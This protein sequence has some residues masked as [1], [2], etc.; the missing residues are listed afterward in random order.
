MQIGDTRFVHLVSDQG[1]VKD[2]EKKVRPRTDNEEV[3]SD[4]YVEASD[5]AGSQIMDP[6]KMMG[7][8]RQKSFNMGDVKD[9]VEELKN[10]R[11]F[12]A[13]EAE[14]KDIKRELKALHGE[15]TADGWKNVKPEDKKRLEWVNLAEAGVKSS[16]D[17]IKH[18]RRNI[19][20]EKISAE[21]GGEIPS[22]Y[23]SY[24]KDTNVPAGE[25]REILKVTD[26]I[27]STD[28]K[29]KLRGNN[30]SMLMRGD[31]WS[32]KMRLLDD[33]IQNPVKNGKPVEV[34]AEYY[35][36]GSPEM[37]GRL[38]KAAES[39]AKVRAVLDPG[40]IAGAGKNT[41]DATSLGVR[42]DVVEQLT[43][44]MEGHD[45]GVTLYPNK[46]Q[47]GGRDEIMHRKIFR[48][49]EEV[50]FGG[51][52][53]SSGSGENV[54]FGMMIEGPAARRIG[55]EFK[56]D[57][58]TSTGKSLEDIYGSQ[59]DTIRSEDSTIKMSGYGFEGLLSSAYGAKAGLTGSETHE[60]K[61]NKLINAAKAEGV[62]VAELGDF[63]DADHDGRVSSMDVRDSL[64]N[65]HQRSVTLSAR[66]KEFLASQ[67]EATVDRV[68]GDKNI[69]ALR[70]INLPEGKTPGGVEGRDVLAVGSSS[71]ERQALVLDAIASA[72]KHIKISAFVLNDEI[73]KLLVEKKREKEAK[74]ENFQVQVIMDPG[75]YGY[76]G[77]PNEP[78]YK[79]LEDA[80]IPVKWSLLDRTDPN[81]DRKNHSKLIM[82]DKM[83]LTGST[84][85]SSK[86]LRN[87]WEVSD[88]VYY[89]E[90]DPDSIRKQQVIEQDF[91]RMWKNEAID[92][93]TKTQAANHYQNYEGDDKAIKIDRYRNTLLRTFCQEISQYETDI[94]TQIHQ[95]GE[96]SDVRSVVAQKVN[97]GESEGYALLSSIPEEKLAEMRSSLPSWRNLQALRAGR[98]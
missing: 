62:S 85:F 12:K 55:E 4:Q 81:H 71:V 19:H 93:E 5:G 45:M 68:N 27:H 76:G 43:R 48:V 40:H 94:G 33:A 78:A 61:L 96:R 24:F 98:Q 51:M 35:E 3:D 6:Q 52:N 14:L 88:V 83:V 72:D 29:M 7:L 28:S 9:T 22:T 73:S 56:Q 50:V 36:L 53:A 2:Q 38:R 69:E 49:G 39:G 75:L 66:G 67:V 1:V 58:E 82:T 47:L 95:M 32:T 54:D 25:M 77:T 13:S 18:T 60:L 59:L 63:S 44:G 37:V 64:L 80:G 91:D 26:D 57:A 79:R 87:N 8:V 15:I 65:E 74:G 86:G 10:A 42:A 90:D 16:L 11:G 70:D 31:I 17:D 89:N 84:N 20:W 23:E 97:N 46:E 30:V 34:D 21:R 92:I 41:F